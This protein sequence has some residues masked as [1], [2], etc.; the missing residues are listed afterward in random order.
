MSN[1]ITFNSWLSRKSKS[2]KNDRDLK[3]SPVEGSVDADFA[4][5]PFYLALIMALLDHTCWKSTREA[6]EALLERRLGC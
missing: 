5:S 4:T 1:N 3:K 2:L 6:I